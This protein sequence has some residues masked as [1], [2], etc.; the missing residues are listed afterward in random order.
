MD[1][2]TRIID[3]EETLPAERRPEL[4]ADAAEQITPLLPECFGLVGGGEG[5][6]L[7]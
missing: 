1:K 2:T 7:V 3:L 4:P 6:L 5:I